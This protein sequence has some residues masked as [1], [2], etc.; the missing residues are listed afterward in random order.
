[1]K[2]N[3]I[4]KVVVL[5]ILTTLLSLWVVYVNAQTKKDSI[6]Y[7]QFRDYTEWLQKQHKQRVEELENPEKYQMIYI[8]KAIIDRKNHKIYLYSS[9][10]LYW[11]EELG[12]GISITIPNKIKLPSKRKPITHGKEWFERPLNYDY[13]KQKPANW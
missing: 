11:A 4:N 13:R 3:K 12:A 2:T 9:Y 8:D 6:L 1:M 10:D 7:N 5:I